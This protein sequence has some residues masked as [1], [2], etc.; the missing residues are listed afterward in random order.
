MKSS[1]K[2]A[3]IPEIP[4]LEKLRHE[5]ELRQSSPKLLWATSELK[6]S[7]DY[8]TILCLIKK[9]NLKNRNTAQGGC[10]YL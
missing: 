1:R 10:A 7:L 8:I 9:K 2:W 5:D 6:A 4:T 3:C